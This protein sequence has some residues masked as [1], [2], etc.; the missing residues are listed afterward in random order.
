[1]RNGELFTRFAS[2]ADLSPKARIW[3]GNDATDRNYHNL[4]PVSLSPFDIALYWK[5]SPTAPLHLI[6]FYSLNLL[7]LQAGGYIGP[8]KNGKVRL[9]FYHDLDDFIYIEPLSAPRKKLLIGK[10]S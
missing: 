4:V 9:R 2:R 3:N 5:I 10:Y 8:T 6:G 7:N 1:M